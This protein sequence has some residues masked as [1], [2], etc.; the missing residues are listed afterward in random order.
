M[1]ARYHSMEKLP[2]E[3]RAQITLRP[4]DEALMFDKNTHGEPVRAQVSG[5]PLTQG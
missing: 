3:L 5:P 1:L 4:E 2:K